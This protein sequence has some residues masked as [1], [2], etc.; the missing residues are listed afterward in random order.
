MRRYV[1]KFFFSL[2][3]LKYNFWIKF[4]KEYQKKKLK[5][6]IYKFNKDDIYNNVLI[7]TFRQIPFFLIFRK[8]KP[9]LWIMMRG[10]IT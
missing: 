7:Y 1:T 8:L 2:E 6:F 3:F 5:V 4:K 9:I 10:L